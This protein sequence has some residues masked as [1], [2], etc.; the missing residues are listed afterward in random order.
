[1][2]ALGEVEVHGAVD[3]EVIAENGEVVRAPAVVEV[4]LVY[5]RL[6]VL[7]SGRMKARRRPGWRRRWRCC[8][9]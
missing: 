8:R 9:G 2:M 1:M 6:R 5:D 4:L 7:P 3:C